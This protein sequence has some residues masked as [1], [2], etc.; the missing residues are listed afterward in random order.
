VK[1]LEDI[2][3]RY[4][5]IARLQISP[6]NT[7]AIVE[8]VSAM[9]AQGAA[10]NLAYYKVNYITPIYLEFAPESILNQKKEEKPEESDEE[11]A[12]DDNSRTKTVF[13]KNLNFKTTETELEAL[14]ANANLKGKILSA[15]IV[16]R[17]D[18]QQSKGYGFVELETV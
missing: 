8:Y 16:R 10:R 7:L 17:S 1:E 14:F 2:F 6:F 18:N 15:K 5:E 12:V 3:G 11:A 9:Q 4:G 13:I